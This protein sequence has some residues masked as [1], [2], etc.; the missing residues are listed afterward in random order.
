MLSDEGNRQM[1]HSI[2]I[3]V[4]YLV[5]QLIYKTSMRIEYQKYHKCGEKKGTLANRIMSVMCDKE[6]YVARPMSFKF[7]GD[8]LV[9]V[10]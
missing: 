8:T 9:I 1:Q 6:R 4:D 2:D 5:R 10:L 3:G 7:D